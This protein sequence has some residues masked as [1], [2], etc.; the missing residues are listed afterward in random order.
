MLNFQKSEVFIKEAKKKFNVIK[1]KILTTI[2]NIQVKQIGGTFIPNALTK[3]DID[4][5][6]RVKHENFNKTIKKLEI[7]FKPNN[8]EL[9]TKDFAIFKDQITFSEKIDILVVTIDSKE[10]IRSK[11]TDLLKKDVKF[12]SEYNRLKIKYSGGNEAKYKIAKTKFYDKLE[13]ILLYE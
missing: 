7:V 9:W 5:L 2:P 10:D 8:K 4:I 1:Q 13:K 12:L 3:G 11:A 6:V